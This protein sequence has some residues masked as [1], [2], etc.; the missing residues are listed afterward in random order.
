MIATSPAR[1]LCFLFCLVIFLEMEAVWRKRD[2]FI[3]RIGLGQG[4][5]RP[6]S[7]GVLVHRRLLL[8][9]H[10]RRP[11][12]SR[13]KP[14]MK[15]VFAAALLAL[16]ALGRPVRSQGP[17]QG[18]GDPPNGHTWEVGSFRPFLFIC[19]AN[20]TD[21]N[22][23]RDSWAPAT[24]SDQNG[25]LFLG[26]LVLVPPTSDY[27]FENVSGPVVTPGKTDLPRIPTLMASATGSLAKLG[28]G[29]SPELPGKA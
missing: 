13:S 25:T 7:S 16:L 1:C 11:D 21:L 6:F 24:V 26:V 18:P 10:R 20:R 9:K 29:R 22:L 2:S 15:T 27:Y 28:D 4:P 19:R 12:L 17:G 3:A 8:I 23:L 14:E 5:R